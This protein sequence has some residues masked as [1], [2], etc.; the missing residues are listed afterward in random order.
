VTK[1]GP[2][3]C[4]KKQKRET[5]VLSQKSHFPPG[6]SSPFPGTGPG[7]REETRQEFLSEFNIRLFLLVYRN[8][9]D[10]CISLLHPSRTLWGMHV[11]SATWKAKAGELLEPRSSRPAWAT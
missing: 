4:E 1:H 3:G 11:V 10:F 6:Y 8:T 9:A 7:N 5:S 2:I